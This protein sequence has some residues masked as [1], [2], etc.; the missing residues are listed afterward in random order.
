M[1]FWFDYLFKY[2][3]ISQSLLTYIANYPAYKL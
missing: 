1:T 2:S 3:V